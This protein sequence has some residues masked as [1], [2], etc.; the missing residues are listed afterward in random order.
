V[1]LRPPVMLEA[2]SLDPAQL[3]AETRREPGRDAPAAAH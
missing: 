1:P 3:G 2:F